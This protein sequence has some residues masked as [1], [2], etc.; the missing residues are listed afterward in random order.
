MTSCCTCSYCTKRDLALSDATFQNIIE[1]LI[2]V[3]L[4]AY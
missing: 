1:Q 2:D 3:Y 4:D